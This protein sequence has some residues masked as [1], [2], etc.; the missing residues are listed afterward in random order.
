M[1]YLCLD[2]YLFLDEEDIVS[3]AQVLLQAP[4]HGPH[5]ERNLPTHASAVES[6]LLTKTLLTSPSRSIKKQIDVEA[7]GAFC[8]L[9]N[10][11]MSRLV[12]PHEFPRK[13]NRGPEGLSKP[14]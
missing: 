10:S 9:L 6:D 2:E 7:L 5:V 4:G 12:L 14:A 3:V 11:L 1:K 13:T 8:I